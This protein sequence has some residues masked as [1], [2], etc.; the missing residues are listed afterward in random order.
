MKKIRAIIK[1]T[2][3]VFYTLFTFGIYA[4]GLLVPKLLSKQYEPWRNLFMR[5]WAR[6]VAVIFNMK[7]TTEGTPPVAPF[8]MVSNHLSY[9][10]IIPLYLNLRCTFV[11]KKA[12]RSWPFL[13]FMV[14][15]V[16]VIFVDRSKRGDVKRVNELLSQSMNRYQG[17]IVFPEGTSSGGE[18]VLPFH[19]SLLQYPASEKIP[20]HTA[21]IS[22]QTAEGDEP[23]RDSVCFFGARHSFPEHVFKLAQTKKIY[24]KIRFG[25]ET[26]QSSNRKELAVELHK[27]V[28]HI[29]EP[30]SG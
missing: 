28:Q 14:N 30:T 9:M 3:L 5:T 27:K 6:G 1:L 11:A 21:A 7:F 2:L 29:L 25:E 16:G 10:D 18:E 23:A 24:C 15:A 12:V 17:L 22:Y 4:V 13:G 26:V 20:V 19:T 8:F